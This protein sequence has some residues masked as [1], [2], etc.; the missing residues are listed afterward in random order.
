MKMS[1]STSATAHLK[2]RRL[3]FILPFV[4]ILLLLLQCDIT[5]GSTNPTDSKDNL[6]MM[7]SDSSQGRGGISADGENHTDDHDAISTRSTA[8]SASSDAETHP[9]SHPTMLLT[10]AYDS[11]PRPSCFIATGS[12]ATTDALMSQATGLLSQTGLQLN[13]CLGGGEGR[14]NRNLPL[15]FQIPMYDTETNA[16]T[17]T[18]AEIL[19]EVLDIL[20]DDD[21]LLSEPNTSRPRERLRRSITQERTHPDDDEE[22]L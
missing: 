11:H 6:K 21:V 5:V 13:P 2:S 20:A 22:K 15:R 7:S 12:S 17:E 19:Q 14:L 1:A 16:R 9:N 4:G 18:T 3:S 8:S 10:N